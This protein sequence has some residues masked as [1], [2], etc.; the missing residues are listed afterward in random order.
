[1]RKITIVELLEWKNKGL[2]YNYNEKFSPAH[3]CKKLFVIGLCLAEGDGDIVMEEDEKEANDLFLKTP[4]ISLHA[5]SGTPAP[6]ATFVKVSLVHVAISVLVDSANT[7]NFVSEE[8]AK[9]VGLRPLLGGTKSN[10]YHL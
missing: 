2:S 8:L 7:H 5:I 10:Y 1:M 4:K 6:K 3:H 9:K